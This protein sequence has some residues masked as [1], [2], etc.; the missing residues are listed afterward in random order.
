MSKLGMGVISKL[1][2]RIE[3][4]FCEGRERSLA[5]TKL[6]ECELW[7]CRAAPSVVKPGERGSIGE[8]HWPPLGEPEILGPPMPRPA[9]FP[10]RPK[11]AEGEGG[12][13][14]RGAAV[15]GE[16]E[17]QGASGSPS[18]AEAAAP[19]FV[20]ICTDAYERILA[21]S[22]EEACVGRFTREGQRVLEALR[23]VIAHATETSEEE[24][25][26][27]FEREA[28]IQ[29]RRAV[30]AVRPSQVPPEPSR[31]H[32]PSDPNAAQAQGSSGTH[33]A[34]GVPEPDPQRPWETPDFES[35]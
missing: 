32:P 15:S 10:A 22:A 33:P 13:T 19:A 24:V 8:P 16:E 11:G 29:R 17:V 7:L 4:E 1:R 5:L 35:A 30:P 25:Q 20:E 23:A 26:R 18:E 3:V 34:S 31:Y 12:E 21:M 14:S 28:S 27:R 9:P 6:D 2:E